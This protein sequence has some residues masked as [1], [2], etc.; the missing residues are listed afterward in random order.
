MCFLAIYSQVRKKTFIQR[1]YND[2]NAL[3][4]LKGVGDQDVYQKAKRF[5][6]EVSVL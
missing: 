5:V 2:F 3:G 1:I 6:W 4:A